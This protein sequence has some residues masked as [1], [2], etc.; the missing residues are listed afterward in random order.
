MRVL[1]GF[2][3]HHAD[4]ATARLHLFQ[5]GVVAQA[6]RH[7]MLVDIVA[8]V[9][10]SVGEP[11][12]LVIFAIGILRVRLEMQEVGADRAVAVLES[13][14]HDAVFHLHHL[15][16]GQD[17]QRVGRGAAP[18]R[19]PGASHAFADRARL[20]DVRSAAGTNDDGLGAEDVEVSGAHI[21]AHGAG[22][23]VWL[24]PSI[25]RWVTMMRL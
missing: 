22:D 14:Q 17:R 6:G 11:S 15:G 3:R 23:A 20:E 12:G 8:D 18:R 16:A 10:L 7:R 24:G 13:R 4:G 1:E 9:S 2:L 25:S 21:E 19:I 5:E